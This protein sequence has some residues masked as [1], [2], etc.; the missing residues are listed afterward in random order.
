MHVVNSLTNHT[1]YIISLKRKDHLS[2][3]YKTTGTKSIGVCMCVC[4][5]VCVSTKYINLCFGKYIYCQLT[6][7]TLSETLTFPGTVKNILPPTLNTDMQAGTHARARTHKHKLKV[8]CI[9]L[10]CSWW[11]CA[12]QYQ[13][14][15]R[16]DLG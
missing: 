2:Q 16:L 6:F 10:R 15:F 5:C 8:V 13:P 4:V 14:H 9:L 7:K 3:S 12:H 1:I 11:S